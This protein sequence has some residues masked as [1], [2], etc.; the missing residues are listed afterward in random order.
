M[1]KEPY[2]YLIATRLWC[3]QFR[4]QVAGFWGFFSVSVSG[5]SSLLCPLLGDVCIRA[6]TSCKHLDIPPLASWLSCKVH[7]NVHVIL[8]SSNLHDAQRGHG[9]IWKKKSWGGENKIVALP[10]SCSFLNSALAIKATELCPSLFK[11]PLW[12]FVVFALRSSLHLR[13]V[14]PWRKYRLPHSQRAV[15]FFSSNFIEHFK[16][17]YTRICWQAEACVTG[18][19]PK[20]VA[21]LDDVPHCLHW[22]EEHFC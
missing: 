18:G 16:Q 21:A 15:H 8:G 11:T 10:R 22:E 7:V 19:A 4:D 9:L 5:G 20:S 17:W 12:S 6:R 2:V 13:S 14:T 1:Q 3:L